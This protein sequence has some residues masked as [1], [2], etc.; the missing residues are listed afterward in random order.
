[1]QHS[2]NF[3]QFGKDGAAMGER[4]WGGVVPVGGWWEIF[5]ARDMVCVGVLFLIFFAFS[6]FAGTITILI[7]PLLF[8]PY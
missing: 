7:F 3:G 1:M 5:L 8:S 6:V 2:M 4:R